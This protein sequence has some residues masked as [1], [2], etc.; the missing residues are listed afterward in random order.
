MAFYRMAFFRVAFFCVAGLQGCIG[1]ASAETLQRFG[2][3]AEDYAQRHAPES[4]EAVARDFL[5]R[6]DFDL[7][8][9]G[10]SNPRAPLAEVAKLR[11]EGKWAAALEVFHTYFLGKLRN[12]QDFGLTAWDVHPASIGIA[13][14]WNYPY[15]SLPENPDIEAADRL[16]QGFWGEIEIGPPGQVNWLHPHQTWE[17]LSPA[18]PGG[19]PAPQLLNGSAL[20]PLAHAYIATGEEKYLRA[21]V[22]YLDDWSIHSTVTAEYPHPS[23]VPLNLRGTHELI[24][25]IRLLGGLSLAMPFER[26]SELLPPATLA[27]V[28]GKYWDELILLQALYL[29]T[30]THNWTPGNEYT[31]LGLLF[32]EFKAAPLIFR[33]GRRRMIEDNAVT[34]N[35]RDGSENQQCPWYN[36]NYVAGVGQIFPLLE[37]RKRLPAWVELPWVAELKND[38]DWFQEIREH[39]IARIGYQL[40]LRTP[41]GSWP[42][43]VRGTDK[44]PGG[45]D[46]FHV[47]PQAF[48]DPELRRIRLALEDATRPA[49]ERLLTPDSGIRPTYHSEWFPYG[50]YNLVREGWEA[51]SG[52]GHMFTSPAPGAYGGRR[53]RS[54]NNFFGLAAFGQD[55][56]VEDKWDR[57]GLMGS[58]ITVDGLPQDFLAGTSRV[59]AVAGHKM[60]PAVAWTE[61][62][63]WRWHASERFNVMEGVYEGPYA[64]TD[65]L[66]LKAP[67]VPVTMQ[68]GGAPLDQALQ[69]IR[70]QR[71]VH[72]VRDARLWIVTDRLRG[73]GEHAYKQFWHLPLKPGSDPAFT[74]DEIEVSPELRRVRTASDSSTSMRGVEWPQ[75][76]VSMHSFS[77]EELDYRTIA[78]PR[79]TA[80]QHYGQYRIELGWKGMDDTLVVTAIYP[81]APGL[82][83]EADIAPRQ[84]EG[85]GGAVGFEA[86]IPSGGTVRYL[87]APGDTP[88]ILELGIAKAEAESLLVTESGGIVMGCRRFALNGTLVPVGHTDFEFTVPSPATD[89]SSLVITPIYRPIAPVEIGPARNVFVDQVEVTMTSRTP[90]VEIRYTLDGSEPTPQSTLYE[91]PFTLAQNA[92]VKAR[93]YRPGVTENP[94]HTSGTHATA[95][96]RAV[97]D[98]ALPVGAVAVRNP[99][100]GL[101]ARYF[102]DDWRRLWLRFDS[103]EALAESKGVDAF[104]LSVVPETNPPLGEAAAPRAKYYTVEYTGYIEVPET[105]VYTL[106][107]PREFVMPDIDSGYELRVFLGQHVVPWAWRT[108]A[109]GLNEWYPSTRLHAQG[110]WSVALEKGLQPIRI[111]YLDYRTDAP[112]RLNQAGL[113]DYIWSGVTP[114]LKISGPG[115]EPQAIPTG[116]LRH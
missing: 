39:M 20:N 88:A 24:Q 5:D 105:G 114:D 63:Y 47:S 112:A 23:L 71:W 90:N 42:V 50:G 44:R 93:A 17:D 36:D 107:A 76:N 14:R 51:D 111:V 9:R 61:P 58:P 52:Y 91:G 3:S 30:N 38:P 92:I 45:T 101:R 19:L 94:P 11:E 74:E 79:K 78:R 67:E 46:A 103:L 65:S 7:P 115:M 48:A 62:G 53:S 89:H 64:K 13:G 56:I 73:S 68:R 110:N 12:P 81:R 96:S 43:G 27:R 69:G 29:R 102:E 86:E 25:M 84:I 41:Q 32:E 113:D 26:Q 22:A 59:P 82:G 6:V 16:L 34:Q 106:H 49:N 35:L 2:P 33:E 60:T 75:A 97:F 108:Q 10:S 72:F 55:L 66:Q 28:L 40:R 95:T 54:N 99:Q 109:V 83:L 85:P 57:Y 100:P 8:T 37:A 21:W 80:R 77:A 4:I 70:H 15:S 1:I 87:A 98:Q 31:L 116:W 104:D 18:E